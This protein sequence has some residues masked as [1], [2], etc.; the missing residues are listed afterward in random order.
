MKSKVSQITMQHNK[1]TNISRR[2]SAS[3][4]KKSQP[5][6]VRGL[7]K[8]ENRKVQGYMENKTTKNWNNESAA[9]YKIA[10]K[11]YDNNFNSSSC[12]FKHS[13]LIN[14]IAGKLFIIQ[15]KLKTSK[16]DAIPN[17]L[18]RTNNKD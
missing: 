3:R 4:R 11:Q 17:V 18:S 6:V 1:T 15:I 8:K 12:H 5:K 16:A 10:I 9:V 7:R 14:T 2:P 13:Q